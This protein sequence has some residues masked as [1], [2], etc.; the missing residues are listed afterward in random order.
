M[1]FSRF[2]RLTRSGVVTLA[3]ALSAQAAL[4]GGSD[5]EVILDEIFGQVE[6]T[7]GGNGQGAPYDI[8]VI[9]ETYFTPALAK[10]FA[11]AME[12]GDLGFDIL[13]DGQDCEIRDIGLEV[14]DSGDTLATGRAR[15]KNM[16][17]DRIIDLKMTRTGETWKVSDVVYQH[18][19]FA[20]SEELE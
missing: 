10:G 15:F 12:A 17:E 5:P 4:A 16:G 8:Y 9:A 18:R 6:A 14:V 3:W 2:G 1:D 13:V 11:T 20:L 7:C 19:P